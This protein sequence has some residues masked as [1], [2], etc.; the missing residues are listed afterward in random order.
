MRGRPTESRKRRKLPALGDR[1]RI[2]KHFEVS[3]FCF[4]LTRS[5]RAVCE[6]FDAGIN[7]FFLTAD[8]HWPSYEQNR[9]GLRMLLQRGGGIRD[10]LV[11]A[12]ASY[13]GSAEMGFAALREL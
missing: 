1:Q 9:R 11:I 4:G 7:F 2:G 6:A 13:V 8:L 10:R 12:A 5:P 3:P